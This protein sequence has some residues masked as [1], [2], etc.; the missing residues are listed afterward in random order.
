MRVSDE[1]RRATLKFINII[2]SG[3]LPRAGFLLES[4][5]VGLLELTDGANREVQPIVIGDLW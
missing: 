1:G 5:L 4:L 3:K 2:L